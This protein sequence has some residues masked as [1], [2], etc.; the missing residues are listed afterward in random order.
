MSSME[1]SQLKYVALRH[2]SEKTCE[3]SL[4]NLAIS[5]ANTH[6]QFN[7]ARKQIQSIE[8]NLHETSCV[9]TMS[10]SKKREVYWKISTSETDLKGRGRRDEFELGGVIVKNRRYQTKDKFVIFSHCQN[11]INTCQNLVQIMFSLFK[12]DHFCFYIARKFDITKL[13]RFPGFNQVKNLTFIVYHPVSDKE[14]SLFWDTITPKK[15]LVFNFNGYNN[16]NR[17][18]KINFDHENLEFCSSQWLND[19]ELFDINSKKIVVKNSVFTDKLMNE[20]I[21]RW[22][23]GEDSKLEKLTIDIQNG[24]LDVIL[25]GIPSK[26]MD[27]I[28]EERDLEDKDLE[29]RE[30]NVFDELKY[31]FEANSARQLT[32]SDGKVASVQLK[33]GTRLYFVVWNEE[34]PKIS[35]K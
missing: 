16:K 30:D 18:G 35:D 11:D 29:F 31:K 12:A 23:S 25:D 21:K 13:L 7:P 17:M 28:K 4:I 33:E 26:S 27:E 8:V 24:D 6:S 2:I 32:R 34:N 14:F 3:M 19:Q 20:Y 22:M 9:I 1:L 15:S 5:L 10:F